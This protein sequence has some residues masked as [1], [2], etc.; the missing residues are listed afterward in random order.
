[1]WLNSMQPIQGKKPATH[2]TD[3]RRQKAFLITLASPFSEGE[4]HKARIQPREE[5]EDFSKLR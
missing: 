5:W 3:H 4:K 1:M 2:A